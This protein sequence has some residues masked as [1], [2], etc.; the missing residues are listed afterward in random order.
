MRILVTGASGYIG[1]NVLDNLKLNSKNIHALAHT[2]V[3]DDDPSVTWHQIDIHDEQAVTQLIQSLNITHLLHCAWIAVPGV[4]WSSPE[5]KKWVTSSQHLISTFFNEGGKRLVVAGSCAEYNWQ[6]TDPHRE[7]DEALPLT[8]YGQSK[9]D[10]LTWLQ[11]L[12][13]SADQSFAWGRIFFTFGPYEHKDR[14]IPHVISSLLEK[15]PALCSHGKQLR[16]FMHVSDLA[17]GFTTLLRE[18][19]EGVFNISSGNSLALRD[20]VMLIGQGLESNELIKL[21]DKPAAENDP[22]IIVGDNT[23]LIT[24]TTWRPILTI[25]DAIEQTIQWWQEN[26]QF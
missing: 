11:H 23:R 2:T 15:K 12:K 10:L 19:G 26:H 14:L 3:I 17:A 18:E 5:N 22:P 16:D 6:S 21:G 13:L 1:R 25:T 9:I 8:L 20:I 4:Y 7:N 24:E